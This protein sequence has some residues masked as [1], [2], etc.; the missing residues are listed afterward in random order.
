MPLNGDAT[1]SDNVFSYQATVAAGTT[2]GAKTLPISITDAELRSGTTSITLTV[3]QILKIGEV[4]GSVS[5]LPT[6]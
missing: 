4:Q 6:A 2:P 5:D 3:Q 1:A